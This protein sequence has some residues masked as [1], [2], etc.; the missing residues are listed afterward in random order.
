VAGIGN[1]YADEALFA[2]RIHP[3]RKTDELSAKQV[4]VLHNSIPGHSPFRFQ[5]CSPRR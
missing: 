3:L 2:A 1:M 5:G 4:Q